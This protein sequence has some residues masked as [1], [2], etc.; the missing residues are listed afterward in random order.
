MEAIRPYTGRACLVLLLLV[1]SPAVHAD[2]LEYA[3]ELAFHKCVCESTIM[4]LPAGCV[5]HPVASA[6]P[7]PKVVPMNLRRVYMMSSP[8]CGDE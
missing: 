2:P 8:L 6:T 3:C 5:A 7:A 4:R 1:T